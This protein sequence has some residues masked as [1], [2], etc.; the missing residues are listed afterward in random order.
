LDYKPFEQWAEEGARDT[1]TLA[2]QRV[3][4]LLDQYQQPALD[5]GKLEA[6]DSYI[7]KTKETAPD[8]FA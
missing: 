8:A 5:P 6:L 1:E 2:S 4:E 3:E 7:A